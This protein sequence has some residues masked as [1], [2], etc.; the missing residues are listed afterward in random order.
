MTIL[1]IKLIYLGLSGNHETSPDIYFADKQGLG[2]EVK[3]AILAIAR[4]ER[5]RIDICN[6]I[7]KHIVVDPLIMFIGTHCII[8]NEFCNDHKYQVSNPY[9]I[10]T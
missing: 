6:F 1:C 10:T 9:N 3:Y 5:S 4:Y 8:N 7:D 2:R